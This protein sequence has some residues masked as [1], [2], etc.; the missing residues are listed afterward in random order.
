MPQRETRPRHL[1]PFA[2]LLCLTKPVAAHGPPDSSFQKIVLAANINQPMEVAVAPDLRVFFLDRLGKVQ[3]YLPSNQTTITAGT[4]A[5]DE[6]GNHGLLGIALDPGFASNNFIYLYYSPL[7]PAVSRLSRFTI[8]G[9]NL[10]M[11]LGEGAAVDSD[12]AHLLPRG[13]LAHVRSRRQLVPSTG[14]NT[15]PV[16]SS[17]YAPDRRAPGRANFDAQKSAGNTNDLRGKI[18]RIKPQTDGTY[19]IP[20]ATCSR[21]GGRPPRDLRHGQPQPV[22]HQRRSG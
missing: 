21:S 5:V 20:R 16:Q 13:W 2:L 10:D 18:L 3:L 12:H 1:L 4:L 17:G 14:D 8:V 11:A 22:P 19:T 7:T 6:T 9:N 15:E